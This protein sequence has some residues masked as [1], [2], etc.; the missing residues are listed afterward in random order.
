MN[1]QKAKKLRRIDMAHDRFIGVMLALG[2][3]R[4]IDGNRPRSIRNESHDWYDNEYRDA[5]RQFYIASFTSAPK[6]N[7]LTVKKFVRSYIRWLRQ[8]VNQ[9][10]QDSKEQ[11]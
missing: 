5:V 2:M 9:Q 10:Q 11:E 8:R 7:T 1:E 6:P 3:P 4:R